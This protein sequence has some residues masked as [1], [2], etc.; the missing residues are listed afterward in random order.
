M[1]GLQDG[2]ERGQEDGAGE[3]KGDLV[4][5]GFLVERCVNVAGEEGDEVGDRVAG[6]K[7]S[8]RTPET[9]RD[10]EGGGDDAVDAVAGEEVGGY[11][12]QAAK[13]R[14]GTDLNGA[15]RFQDR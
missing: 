2:G 3:Q 12:V 4:G 14:G 5:P 8:L 11:G 9:A 1:K 10:G 15:A 7:V 13:R 6:G